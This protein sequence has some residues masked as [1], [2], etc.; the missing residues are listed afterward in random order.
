MTLVKRRK[1]DT[2]KDQPF[3]MTGIV[4]MKVAVEEKV[5]RGWKQPLTEQEEAING[6]IPQGQAKGN[7]KGKQ[8][9]KE[10]L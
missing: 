6:K 3:G 5:S 8:L 7:V 1:R 2:E 10:E 9:K 4:G